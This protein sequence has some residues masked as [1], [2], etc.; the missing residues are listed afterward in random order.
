MK[1]GLAVLLL[2]VLSSCCPVFLGDEQAEIATIGDS[3]LSGGGSACKN[4]P[5]GRGGMPLYLSE[6]LQEQV[7]SLA[8]SGTTIIPEGDY[9][10]P[11]Q[12]D[13]V[14]LLRPTVHTIVVDGGYNDLYYAWLDGGITDEEVA[15]ISAAMADLMSEIHSQGYFAVVVACHHNRA[16]QELNDPL[17]A[18]REDYAAYATGFGF[19]YYDL[20]ALM[21]AHPEYYYDA[22]HLNDWGHRAFAEAVRDILE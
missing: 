11:W 8:L 17:D 9:H 22:I 1:I 6:L 18:L 10:I 3:I 2:A 14:R 4:M 5:G 13:Q 7:F 20:Q 12:Y 21:Q 19:A 16:L 15:A